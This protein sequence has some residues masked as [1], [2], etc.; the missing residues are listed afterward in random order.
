MCGI[1]LPIQYFFMEKPGAGR[2]MLVAFDLKTFFLYVIPALLYQ[3]S[4]VAY[5]LML[6][7]MN[8]ALGLPM[9]SMKILVT[10]LLVHLLSYTKMGRKVF[11]ALNDVQVRR[12]VK[13]GGGALMCA[14]CGVCVWSSL[15]S[16]LSASLSSLPLSPSPPLTGSPFSISSTPL[17]PPSLL[18]PRSPAPPSILP[19]SSPQWTSL[20]LLLIGVILMTPVA[21][22]G[23]AKNATDA[24]NASG[25]GANGTAS[26]TD[27]DKVGI[28][29]FLFCLN[30]CS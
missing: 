10:G 29:R 18:L 7:V 23:G 27:K 22:E 11:T 1:A 15:S 9:A 28:C 24:L 4:D 20:I 26:L 6:V 13:R 5:V 30:M 12:G 2:A 21:K 8:P 14:V 3:I 25:G 16:Q 19:L 17:P